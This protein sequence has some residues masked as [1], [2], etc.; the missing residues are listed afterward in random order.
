[1]TKRRAIAKAPAPLEDYCEHF[2]PLFRRSNQRESFRQYGEGLLLP[3]ERNKTLTGSVNPEPGV[4]AGLPRAQKVQWFLSESDWDERAVQTE[5]LNLLREEA[6]TAPHAQGVL[7]ID[8]TGDR[9]AG[10]K[11]AHVGRH[12][13]GSVGKIDDGVVSVTSLWADPHVYYP[14]EVEPST[15]ES[16]FAKGKKDPAF[17]T[18]RSVRLAVGPASS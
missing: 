4:G 12:Y 16:Y 3:N 6:T 18:K 17:R 13:L 14:L 2:E 9:K 15:P 5:R 8:E 7:V 11:T 1:M 10:H